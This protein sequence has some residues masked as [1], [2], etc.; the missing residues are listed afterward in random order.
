MY[1]LLPPPFKQIVVDV[2]AAASAKRERILS[3]PKSHVSFR[4]LISSLS[5][6]FR[7]CQ[8]LHTVGTKI[9]QWAR[10]TKVE[11]G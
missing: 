3:Q 10:K 4:F 2:L 6:G 5:L 11:S 7:M 9:N 1:H 8:E